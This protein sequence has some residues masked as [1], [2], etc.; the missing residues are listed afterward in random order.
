[1]S[2]CLSN[3]MYRMGLYAKFLAWLRPAASEEDQDE[4]DQIHFDNESVK[5]SVLDAPPAIQGQKFWE[6]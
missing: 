6:P 2:T 3:T 4:A 1:M 5:T